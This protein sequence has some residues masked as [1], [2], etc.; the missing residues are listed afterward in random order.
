MTPHQAD[1]A[2]VLESVPGVLGVYAVAHG[3]FDF[4]IE[5]ESP[6]SIVQAHYALLRVMTHEDCSRVHFFWVA[7]SPSFVR[8]ATLLC[9]S[10]HDREAARSRLPPRPPPRKVAR[11]ESDL[12]IR[13]LAIDVDDS[14]CSAIERISCMEVTRCTY[15][16]E[17]AER[18]FSAPF[19]A[20]VVGARD[21]QRPQVLIDRIAQEDGEASRRVIVVASDSFGGRVANSLRMLGYGNPIFLLPLQEP[22]L[23]REIFVARDRVPSGLANVS[24]AP[25]RLLTP[26]ALAPFTVL[27][28][29]A[30]DEVHDALRRIFREDARHL[31]RTDPAEAAEIALTKPLHVIIAGQ[32]AALRRGTFIETIAKEDPAGADRIIVVAPERDVHYTKHKLEEIGRSNLVLPLPIDDLMLQEEVFRH[33]PELVARVAVGEVTRAAPQPMP[34][35]RPRSV[36]VVDDD[37]STEILLAAAERFE[38]VDVSFAKTSMEA[39]EHVVSREVDLIVVGATMRGDGG[40]PFYRMLWRL[41]PELKTRTILVVPH[42]SAP[43]SVRVVERPLTRDALARAIDAFVRR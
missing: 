1:V 24:P 26:D 25:R 11:P 43:P 10:A 17:A 20:I 21:V 22:L 37:R 29:D 2:Y 8:A 31:I 28:V 39:F 42:D 9:L 23:R 32:R 7:L 6:R 18:A 16:P 12:P 35:E 13:I 3:S 5:L 30:G 19:H 15:A 40:E 41:K 36:L 27:I 4:A 38:D 33:H 14:E 34:I